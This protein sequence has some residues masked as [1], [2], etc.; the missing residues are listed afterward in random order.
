MG[1]NSRK[2]FVLGIDGG[3]WSLLG[4]LMDQGYMPNLKKVCENGVS[5][6]LQSTQPPYTGPA[7]VSSVT[8]M[9]PGKHGV[10]GFTHQP[11]GE[12]RRTFVSSRTIKV[13]KI[14][15]Y[16]ENAGRTAGLIN[17]PVTY[18]VERLNGFMIPGFLTPQGKRNFTYPTS[19]YEELL[20]EIGTYIINVRI[21]G[22]KIN[23]EEQFNE[24]IENIIFCTRKRF[25]AM[26]VLWSKYSPDYFMIVF[27]CLD[28][29]Q[30]KF[31]KFMDM[32]SPLY[33]TP[34]AERARPKLFEVYQLVDEILGYI[35]RTMDD[36]MALYIISDHGFGP[37][38]K[39]VFLNKWLA[40]QGL[41]SFKKGQIY[42]NKFLYRIGLKKLGFSNRSI[43]VSDN[44]IDGCI[45]F[46]NTLFFSSDVYEQGIYFNEG[47][48]LVQK[49]VSYEEARLRLR[50]NI[51][52]LKDPSNGELF[53]DEVRFREEVFWGPHVNQAPDLL[54][55]MKDYGYLLNKSIPV[56][57][58]G[59]LQEV[60]GPQGCHRSEG[61]F[62]AYGEGVCQNK[63]LNA[64]IMDIA[65]TV[66]YNMN[67][68]VPKQ[69][70]GKVL[71]NIFTSEFQD[72]TDVRYSEARLS[73]DIKRSKD[74]EYSLEEETEVKNR[75][76]ELGY[77]D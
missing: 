26:R 43:A 50:D 6:L 2:V 49:G 67:I 40:Q 27:N 3:S 55:K 56:R 69:M 8:G 66:L 28:K 24:F 53:V 29:I 70:D 36:N 16:L 30:H 57:G 34:V 13:P 12:E 74:T 52:A 51:L 76:R 17:V 77:L 19:L 46:T 1:E 33:D 20:K 63:K 4:S 48:E 65:P 71:Q 60:K 72:V 47:A 5:G 59:F 23:T 14:W 18:P 54:L 35:L 58:D 41:L 75:L 45:D 22:R 68:P 7:W 15:Q 62:A 9:N 44:P 25:E 21:A 73:T 31:W 39:R 42:L 64:S 10:F 38:E 37:F 32:G 11:E 61:I